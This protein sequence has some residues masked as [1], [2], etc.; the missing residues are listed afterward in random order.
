VPDV[1]SVRGSAPDRTPLPDADA[2]VRCP[3]GET[4]V[5]LETALFDPRSVR[6]DA[7]PVDGVVV[8]AFLGVESPAWA[9]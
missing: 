3:D 8:S 9:A 7:R 2:A 6:G 4:V 5:S 1:G